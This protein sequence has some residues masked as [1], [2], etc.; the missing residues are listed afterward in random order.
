L[1]TTNEAVAA[2]ANNLRERIGQQRYDLWFATNTRFHWEADALTVG[3]PNWFFKDWLQKQFAA[4]LQA[5]AERVLGRPVEVGFRIDPQLFR[6]QRQHDDKRSKDDASPATA[7][8]EVVRADAAHPPRTPEPAKRQTRRR[9]LADFIVGACNRVAHAA[10]VS[11][12]DDPGSCPTPLVL[13]GP[14]GLGK[15]HLLEGIN[16]ELREQR[17]DARIL[18]LTAEDFTNRFLG[19]IHAGKQTSFRR[20]FRDCD[21]LL[22]DDLHFLARKTATQ[23]E[24]L[25]TLE[26]L[27]RDGRPVVVTCDCHPRLAEIFLPELTDRLAGGAVWGLSSPDL[28]TRRRILEAKMG[29]AIDPAT[30][31]FLAEKLRGNVRELEGALHS[32]RHLARVTE[33]PITPELAQEALAE[34]LRASVRTVQLADIEKA[35]STVFALGAGILQSR[36]RRTQ[37]AYPRMLAMYLARKHTAATYSEVG[38]F[39]GKRNHSTVVAAEKKV[40]IWLT[41][42]ETLPVGTAKVAVKDLVDRFESELAR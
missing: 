11:I 6:H 9:R 12:V 42:K 38:H 31:D 40:R 20:Q 32:V 5:A 29:D 7:G 26:A 13:H 14:V 23:E 37:I 10:L 8:P 22:V 18:H 27:Q 24:F 36:Q 21:A 17:P 2:L 28:E 15:S 34:V 39:F 4:D 3:V 25:H 19:S 33:R 41:T 16:A 1:N 30:L 35:V